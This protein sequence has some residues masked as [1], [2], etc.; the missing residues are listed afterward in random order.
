MRYNRRGDLCAGVAGGVLSIN[1][2][3]IG[4]G[5]GPKWLN[6]HTL[7]ANALVYDRW[8]LYQFDRAMMWQPALLDERGATRI[9]AGGGNWAATLAAS[10]P[11][12]VTYGEIDGQKFTAPQP[13]TQYALDG[14]LDGALLCL[15]VTPDGVWFEVRWLDGTISDYPFPSS[16]NL[17]NVRMAEGGFCYLQEPRSLVWQPR[18]GPSRIVPT[19][20]VPFEPMTWQDTD[21]WRWWLYHNEATYLQYEDTATGWQGPASYGPDVWFGADGLFQVATTPSAGELPDTITLTTVHPDTRIPLVPPIPAVPA[22]T[23]N[24]FAGVFFPSR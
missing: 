2:V 16:V 5:G 10:P 9:A 1:R 15:R 12:S 6:D 23:H 24:V 3:A 8:A 19:V 22:F 21:G 13:L 4:F 7:L 17:E 18:N 14:W 11:P 20:D